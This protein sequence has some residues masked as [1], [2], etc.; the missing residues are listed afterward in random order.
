M[1]WT[2]AS[3]TRCSRLRSPSHVGSLADASHFPAVFFAKAKASCQHSSSARRHLTWMAGLISHSNTRVHDRRKYRKPERR[4]VCPR[5]TKPSVED[6]GHFVAG[7]DMDWRVG[8]RRHGPPRCAFRRRGAAVRMSHPR[9]ED[10]FRMPRFVIQSK[11][12]CIPS[13]RRQGPP[14]RHLRVCPLPPDQNSSTPS[15]RLRGD[16]IQRQVVVRVPR[17]PLSRPYKR[18]SRRIRLSSGRMSRPSPRYFCRSARYRR[19]RR[20]PLCQPFSVAGFQDP[21]DDRAQLFEEYMNLPRWVEQP[22][23]KPVSA[24]IPEHVV[25]GGGEFLA[26]RIS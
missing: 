20:V 6:S 4:F 1:T 25:G 18:M 13:R 12:R 5:G 22:H 2:W 21:Q 3:L 7:V 19:R 24:F 11:R 23:G 8:A 16:D 9:P 14:R 17:R 10:R 26:A 15:R